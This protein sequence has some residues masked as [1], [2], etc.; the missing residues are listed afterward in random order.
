[1]VLITR[2]KDLLDRPKKKIG[3]KVESPLW[4][5]IKTFLFEKNLFLQPI[6]YQQNKHFYK[7]KLHQ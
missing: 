2:A 1:M 3:K 7:R 6:G 5:E 4:D